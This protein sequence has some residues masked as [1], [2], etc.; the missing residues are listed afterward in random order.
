MRPPSLIGPRA[1]DLLNDTHE[2]AA[3]RPWRVADAS[4]LW[5]YHLNYFDD[6]VSRDFEDRRKWHLDL[7]RDWIGENPV[8]VEPAW[9]PYPIS[10]R[11]VNW[12][13]SDLTE[14]IL[15][16]KALDS[17]ALQARYL[18][19]CCEHHLQGNHL[20]V[21][22]KALVF[23]GL[24]FDGR[25]EQGEAAQWL[26]A[27]FKIAARQ[28]AEQV[29]PDG[30]HFEQSPM[31]HALM[32]EDALDL[33]NIGRA[34]GW[35]E[36]E[37]WVST[38][39]LMLDYLVAATHPDG[40]IALF[41]D[42]AL[43]VALLPRELC[44][45]GRRLGFEVLTELRDGSDLRRFPDSG[46]VRIEKGPWT[47][48]ADTG[49]IGPDY[50]PGHAHA[51]S[52]T[53]ELSVGHQRLIVDTGTGVYSP[54][55][56]R[57][58]QRSTAAHNTVRVD[59][60]DSSEVWDSFRVARRAKP[61]GLAKISSADGHVVCTAGHDGY[62]RLPGRVIHKRTFRVDS[63][64]ISIEDDVAGQGTHDLE[65][66][67]HFHPDVVL[68]KGEEGWRAM[69]KTSGTGKSRYPLR[70][71]RR[72]AYRTLLLLSRVRALPS[73]RKIGRP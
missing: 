3:N 37:M 13:K 52:L 70:R 65:L 10:R 47:L 56:E 32:V 42:A 1:F 30:S 7:I 54:G 68:E 26:A 29:R 57:S 15:D 45:Y 18:S 28:F 58:Y 22:G 16:R 24:F 63:G 36:P 72:G 41:N 12:I 5:N 55:T 53:F 38:I 39:N 8:G 31:Y 44:D 6:L 25:C 40:E 73:G 2:L 11:I 71:D 64:S 43:N 20:W 4:R 17:L 59:G 69:D 67:L 21:N 19:G 9:E 48:L 50:I 14:P 49:P 66:R 34:F 51:D 27:G 23:A 35:Q 61:I 62:T 60:V 33:I 46:L